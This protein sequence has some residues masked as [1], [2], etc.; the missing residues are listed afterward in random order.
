MI[1]KRSARVVYLCFFLSGFSALIY[2]IAWLSRIQ[3]VMGHTVY[4][5]ATT[6]AAYLSGLAL[7]ALCVP[8]LQ[9]SGI[10]SF[11]LYLFAELLVGAYGIGFSP[12]LQ[13]VQIPYSKII[14]NLNFSLPVLSLIQFIFCGAIVLLPTLLMGT[15]LPLLAHYLYTEENEIPVKIPLLYAVNTLGACL[16]SF[17]AGFII[18]P[19]IGYT[20]SILLAA[21]INIS[22]VFIALLLFP[23]LKVPSWPEI[24]SGLRNIL[25]KPERRRRITHKD[26]GPCT[27]LFVSGM[28]SMLVQVSWN[29]LAALGFGPSAYIFPLVTTTVLTGMVLGSLAFRR[30]SAR[31][32]TAKKV[33]VIL[34]MASACILLIGNYAFTQVPSMV[35][36]WHQVYKPDFVAYTFLEWIWIS[37]CLLPASAALGALFP[38][39]S[40]VLTWNK[41]A[42]SHTLGIGYALNISG[43]IFGAIISSFILLPHYG[44]EAVEKAAFFFLVA[45]S[46]YLCLSFYGRLPLAASLAIPAMMIF[47][48]T[49]GYNWPLLT[50]GYF[51]N[52]TKP[53]T[54]E[55]L[56][57]HGYKGFWEY[58]RTTPYKLVA[59]KDDPHATVSVYE[60]IDDPTYRG[61]SINGKTDG[62]NH[63]DLT[64]TQLLA[65]FPALAGVDYR[66]TLTIGLGTG[67]TVA[68]TL[69]YPEIEISKVIELSPAMIDFAQKYFSSVSREIWND[70]RVV[71]VNR[72]GREYLRYTREKYDLIISEP[73]N[74]WVEGVGSLFTHEYYKLISKR[75]S[76]R[77]IASL[78]LHSY[79]LDCKSVMSVFIAVA[80]VFRS[81]VVFE[82]D[83][84]YFILATNREG[85]F[86][87]RPIPPTVSK[88][89]KKLLELVGISDSGDRKEALRKILETTFVIDR[90]R[91]LEIGVSFRVNR[92]D[93]QYLQ[94]A[95]GRTFW[96]D[97]ECSELTENVW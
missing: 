92:D 1:N 65:F 89:E 10:S 68:S 11:W 61:F 3:L 62:N 27:V 33:L 84:D 5:L 6:I 94:Y 9:K 91:I 63:E 35:F 22:L 54:L 78:W 55:Q 49:P 57:A 70:K 53:I 43:L 72:D 24:Q 83:S 28:V 81:V 23:S 51:D 2:E 85:G 13:L 69:I 77:G 79:G 80:E 60:K 96:Q 88:I 32:E 39:A 40:T 75:L 86:H 7:G 73:S 21:G 44:L 47:H 37:L 18:L 12:L 76:P 25:E 16:G 93:N 56:S 26:W 30:V 90:K 29:R 15:T 38:A 59:V 45:V 52:R 87:F 19:F 8:R 50:A 74:P 58:S 82:V 20:C 14:L 97:I 46:M 36:Y 41:E 64:T 42:A 95:S 34:P 17:G 66:K 71:V 4:A 48:L 67:S 31:I